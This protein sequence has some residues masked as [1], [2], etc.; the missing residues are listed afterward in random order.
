MY[1]HQIILK[2]TPC[3]REL[4]RQRRLDLTGPGA[5]EARTT[6]ADPAVA[7]LATVMRRLTNHVFLRMAGVFS[8]RIPE[9]ADSDDKSARLNAWLVNWFASLLHDLETRGFGPEMADDFVAQKV[10]VIDHLV[11]ENR[12]DGDR[13]RAVTS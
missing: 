3:Y 13:P 11:G 12:P 5:Y 4:L 6:F 1:H 2:G 9:S 7:T 10:A 8:G